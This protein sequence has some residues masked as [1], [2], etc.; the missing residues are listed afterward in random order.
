MP[1]TLDARGLLCPLPSI[2]ARR[3]LTRLAAEEE[4]IVL[5]TDPEAPID[6]AA[7]AA[8]HGRAVVVTERGE[9]EWRVKLG[10][11]VLQGGAA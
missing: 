6:L 7:V 11:A 8:D 2:L 4:L 1:R 9:R 10:P 3:E 5:A